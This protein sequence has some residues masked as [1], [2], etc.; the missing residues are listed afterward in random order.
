MFS[1]RVWKNESFQISSL[2]LKMPVCTR[3]RGRSANPALWSTLPLSVELMATATPP[4][5]PHAH[6]HTHTH[7]ITAISH[8]SSGDE[9]HILNF[10]PSSVRV[11]PA[12]CKLD[13]QAC[14]TGKKIAVKCAGLCPCPAQ[15]EQSSAE[16]KGTRL[17][18]HD[19]TLQARRNSK[20]PLI[21]KLLTW[22]Q[23][24]PLPY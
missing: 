7:T 22:C 24:P 6:T 3:A 11:A 4:R 2:V 20:F 21:K 8:P 12:Q 23:S 13:Y 1:V 17:C 19:C 16:K 9:T 18:T 15:P 5:Y 14:I 10:T